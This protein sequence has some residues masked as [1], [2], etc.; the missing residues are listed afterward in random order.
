MGLGVDRGAEREKLL[1]CNRLSECAGARHH[2]TLL[3]LIEPPFDWASAGDGH[4][5]SHSRDASPQLVRGRERTALLCHA[6]IV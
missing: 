6:G 4:S 2:S 1:N 3:A 5:Q